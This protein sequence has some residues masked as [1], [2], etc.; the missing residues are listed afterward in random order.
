MRRFGS[1]VTIVE[2]NGHVVHREDED[3]T[4]ALEELC[5]DEGSRCQ[6]IRRLRESKASRVNGSNFMIRTTVLKWCWKALTF[7]LLAGARQTPV[8]LTWSWPA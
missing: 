4:Q 7:S 5:R 3:V 8:A 6:Q 1:E 2:R